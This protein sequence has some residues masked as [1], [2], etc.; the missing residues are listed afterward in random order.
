[1]DGIPLSLEDI[2]TFLSYEGLVEDLEDLE[3]KGYLTLEYPKDIVNGKRE[4]KTT[5]AQGYNIS[6]GKL[7]FPVSKV[8]DPGGLSPTLTATDS[9]KLAVYVGG[10]VRQLNE[11]ELKRLCGFPETMRLPAKVNKYD[12][13]GNMVCPPVI[14]EILE[15]LLPRAVEGSTS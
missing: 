12:L 13:F 1:M 4:P 15:S 7:S 2:R 3:Q 5:L 11:R 9:S 14:T 6:K 8:L 10:T